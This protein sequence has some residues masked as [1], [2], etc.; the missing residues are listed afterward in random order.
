[1]K[2]FKSIGRIKTAS[3]ETLTPVI[4]KAKAELVYHYYQLEKGDSNE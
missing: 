3:V 1:L 2:E 4:G